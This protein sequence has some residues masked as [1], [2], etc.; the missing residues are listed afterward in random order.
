M[1]QQPSEAFLK[2]PYKIPK[3]VS[4]SICSPMNAKGYMQRPV[5]DYGCLR[6]AIYP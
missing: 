3:A 2:H 6:M 1:Y 5:N 4:H